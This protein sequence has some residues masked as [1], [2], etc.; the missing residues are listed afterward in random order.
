M[1][2]GNKKGGYRTSQ[3]GCGFSWTLYVFDNTYSLMATGSAGSLG[4]GGMV[5][6]F[7]EM[8]FF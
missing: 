4:A 5:G 8:G 7:F 3:Q 1:D 2:K 6:G